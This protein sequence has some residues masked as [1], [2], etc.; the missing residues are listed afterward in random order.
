MGQRLGAMIGAVGG[1]LCVLLNG[2][3]LPA[4]YDLVVW[5]VGIGVFVAVVWYAVVRTRSLAA[6]PAP[7]AQ[8]VRIYWLCVIAELIAIP[9]GSQVLVR[10]LDRPV[11]VPV[12]VVFVVGVH[13]LSFARAFGVALF[14]VLGA[15]LIIVA[16][17]ALQVGPPGAA[18]A[19]VAAGA[20]L[21]TFAVVGA[22]QQG[23]LVRPEPR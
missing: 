3:A 8:A 19:G 1:L 5:L 13:F 15:A 18:G 23:R 16:I 11:L 12:W 22:V 6:G 17:A 7:A 14:T 4:P 20:L 2:G 9:V 21:L 10:G